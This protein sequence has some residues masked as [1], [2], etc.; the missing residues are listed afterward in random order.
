MKA[1]INTPAKGIIVE[2]RLDKGRGPVT[3][4][5]VQSGIIKPGDSL[6]AGNAFGKIRSMLNEIGKDVKE[7]GPSI[8][9]KAG[10]NILKLNLLKIMLDS[11]ESNT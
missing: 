5:L 9:V 6:L 10:L 3:T 1:S 2:G 4:L 11:C 7:A 8:P